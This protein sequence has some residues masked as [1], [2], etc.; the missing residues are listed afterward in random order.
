MDLAQQYKMIENLTRQRDGNKL[1][2]IM[3]D[4]IHKLTGAKYLKLHLVNE[5]GNE[6]SAAN[7]NPIE[8]SGVLSTSISEEDLQLIQSVDYQRFDAE[9]PY[10]AQNGFTILPLYDDASMLGMIIIDKD[11]PEQH[12][13][14]TKVLLRVFINQYTLINYCMKDAL[15]GLFNRQ[16]F[17]KIMKRIIDGQEMPSRRKDDAPTGDWYFALIDID[18]FKQVNDQFGHIYGDEVL[19]LFSRI[20]NQSFRGDDLLFRYGGEEFAI[21]LRNVNNDTS[22]RA[23]ERLRSNVEKYDFPQVGK[24]TISI[25]YT[26]IKPNIMIS[27]ITDEAD[28]ALYFAKEH[29]RNQTHHYEHLI[30]SG[31]LS[32]NSYDSQDVEL[33]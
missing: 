8:S 12:K 14:F 3:G 11:I 20:M 29:G 6:I 26:N 21:A 30:Q 32:A 33:F 5:G 7:D 16:A 10:L 23:L 4:I 22:N 15:T 24:V 18:H 17:D 19:L 2:A 27:T 1:C 28:K 9:S 13:L 25:G 31:L